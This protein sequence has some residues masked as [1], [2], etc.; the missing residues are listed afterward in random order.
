MISYVRKQDFSI[1]GLPV[2]CKHETAISVQ[3]LS[4]GPAQSVK[5]GDPPILE[6]LNFE[7]RVGSWVGL[8]G[9]SGV[10]KTTFLSL[11]AGLLQAL[12]GVI[13]LF[14][15][16]ITELNDREMSKFRAEVLGLVFQNFQLDDTKSTLENILLAGY[17]SRQSWN[18]LENKA[19]NLAAIL[20]LSSHLSKPTSVLSGGQRQ[21]VAIAR[22]LLRGPKL[23]LCDEPTGALDESTAQTVLE[24]LSEEQSQGMTLITVTH[25]HKTL[26]RC[27]A[28]FEFSERTLKRVPCE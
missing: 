6:D 20:D 9:P 28:H 14:G 2:D 18:S 3:N 13:T 8:T 10:G 16:P 24:L 11:C 21:R 1:F 27:D 5:A 17:F 22:A 12:S 25:S 23:L 19:K 4:W 15:R 26:E 7:V